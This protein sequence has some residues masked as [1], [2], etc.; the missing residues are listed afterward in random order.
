MWV[1]QIVTYVSEPDLR[2]P[3]C[4]LCALERACGAGGKI[5]FFLESRLERAAILTSFSQFFSFL[6]YKVS[7][8]AS[9]RS[10]ECFSSI[11]STP[12]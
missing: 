9:R 3:L 6:V 7:L 12:S 8:R 10:L 5:D 1:N 11:F 2:F 4:D